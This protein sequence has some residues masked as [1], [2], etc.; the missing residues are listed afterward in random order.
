[1]PNYI[2]KK[3]IVAQLS[4]WLILFCWLIIPLI[5]QIVSILRAA[6]YS[7]EFFDNKIVTKYGILGK[8]EKQTVFIGVSS[9]SVSQSL[10]GKIFKYG[11]VRVDCRGKWDVDT[12]RVKNP[13]GLKEYLE[14]HISAE[15]ITTI[16]A[17]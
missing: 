2:A 14:G 8:N 7:I 17:S 12:K 4:F 3:S 13:K 1:M 10:A 15:G 5:I 9:V 6:I 16:I 11:D